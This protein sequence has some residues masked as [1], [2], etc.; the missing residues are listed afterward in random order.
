MCKPAHHSVPLQ[1]KVAD[2]LNYETGEPG[3]KS[4]SKGPLTINFGDKNV[5]AKTIKTLG[6]GI[7]SNRP[8][9]IKDDFRHKNV[10]D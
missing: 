4:K 3:I 5:T 2:T 7:K 8:I 9:T 10:I 6:C 1:N